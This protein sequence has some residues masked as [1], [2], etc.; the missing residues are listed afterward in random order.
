M[1]KWVSKLCDVVKHG[2]W[3]VTQLHSNNTLLKTLI[4]KSRIQS[5]KCSA[6]RILIIQ[7]L[8]PAAGLKWGVW[9]PTKL[10]H[11]NYVIDVEAICCIYFVIEIVWQEH[12]R[13]HVDDNIRKLSMI[14]ERRV[15]LYLAFYIEDS[16]ICVVYV[17]KYT[18]E[19]ILTFPKIL[20]SHKINDHWKHWH[21]CFITFIFTIELLLSFSMISVEYGRIRYPTMN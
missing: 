1:N 21:K 6:H 17:I 11:W 3:Q 13:N 20:L 8:S 7:V 15:M 4:N 10:I 18:L 16:M 9:D 5:M 19:M 14:C 2:T 12:Q